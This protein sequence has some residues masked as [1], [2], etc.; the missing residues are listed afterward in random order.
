MKKQKRR[1]LKN[2]SMI[3]DVNLTPVNISAELPEESKD[4]TTQKSCQLK[5]SMLLVTLF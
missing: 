3:T 2:R 5:Q 1:E 4:G